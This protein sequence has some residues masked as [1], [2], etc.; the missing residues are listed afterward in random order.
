MT[1]ALREEE[2]LPWL[3]SVPGDVY[4]SQRQQQEAREES[5]R[6]LWRLHRDL[7]HAM[8]QVDSQFYAVVKAQSE[9]FNDAS[10]DP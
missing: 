5:R 10:S 9:A 1:L 4:W 3:Q 2:L 7:E 8:A 6:W